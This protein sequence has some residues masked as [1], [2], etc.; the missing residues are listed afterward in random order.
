MD[1]H[2]RLCSF[3]WKCRVQREIIC[4]LCS[5]R[6]NVYKYRCLCQIVLT[7]A[8]RAWKSWK[9]K[10]QLTPI[11]VLYVDVETFLCP[12]FFCKVH[13]ISVPSN[14]FIRQLSVTILCPSMA[15]QYANSCIIELM[16]RYFE[17]SWMSVELYKGINSYKQPMV[18]LYLFDHVWQSPGFSVQHWLF[19]WSLR[20]FS[21]H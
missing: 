18:Y 9:T 19:T 10:S 2:I 6:I 7:P 16:C 20:N 17:R 3:I 15:R 8:P 21:G 14:A 5:Y 11:T 13:D 12:F 4:C 1:S